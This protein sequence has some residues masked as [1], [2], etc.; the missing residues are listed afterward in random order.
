[1]SQILFNNVFK[2]GCNREGIS[3]SPRGIKKHSTTLLKKVRA[4]CNKEAKYL[5]QFDNGLDKLCAKV[6]S[7]A[8]ET[9]RKEL[10]RRTKVMVKV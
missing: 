6:W 7:D 4:M 9:I 5:S 3:L 1:M 2:N 10:K 8:S